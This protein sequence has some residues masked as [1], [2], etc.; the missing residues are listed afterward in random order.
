MIYVI[1]KTI[2]DYKQVAKDNEIAQAVWVHHP[3]VLR[4]SRITEADQVL[5]AHWPP[6]SGD[7]LWD[8]VDALHA[9]GF[10]QEPPDPYAHA[11]ATAQP[12]LRA[13]LATGR[14]SRSVEELAE[15]LL[16]ALE[17]ET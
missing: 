7:R 10:D 1:A 13:L 3:S 8:I 2:A 12:A 14:A 17:G 4:G 15:D 5:F 6:G 16:E 11:V 9:V